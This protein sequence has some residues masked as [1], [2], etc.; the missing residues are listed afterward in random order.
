VGTDLVQHPPTINMSIKHIKTILRLF[1][2]G[3]LHIK[4][5]KKANHHLA[6]IARSQ[7]LV[8]NQDQPKSFNPN[9]LISLRLFKYSLII[10]R[11]IM[12]AVL[13]SSVVTA[14]L[15]HRN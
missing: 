12:M 5:K 1:S 10:P 9:L 15:A 4:V 8:N 14:W 7:Y 6:I 11:K 3:M 2:R 13:N